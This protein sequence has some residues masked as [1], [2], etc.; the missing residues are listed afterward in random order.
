MVLSLYHVRKTI[1]MVRDAELRI[2]M[3][4]KE[5]NGITIMLVS[6][7]KTCNAGYVSVSDSILNML[8]ETKSLGTV[9]WRC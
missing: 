8:K 6:K 9:C 7:K 3:H 1:V 4:V 5:R 2:D